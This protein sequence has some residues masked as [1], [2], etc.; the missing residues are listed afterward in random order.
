MRF[1]LKQASLYTCFCQRDRCMTTNE[2]LSCCRFCRIHR[3]S[4]P[5]GVIDT[6]WFR[7]ALFDGNIKACI[8]PRKGRITEIPFNR[9]TYRQ[10]HKIENLFA[11]LKDW[12]PNATRYDRC[13][14]TFFS[15]ICIAATVIFNSI[16]G[17]CLGFL[18]FAQTY[19]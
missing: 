12:R 11:K 13:A 7:Q 18:A 3:N 15:A 10:S 4:L 16:N 6:D 8:T 1:V 5:T 2:R 9:L 19:S 17:T 14:H